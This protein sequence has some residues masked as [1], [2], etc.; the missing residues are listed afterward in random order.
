MEEYSSVS[1]PRAQAEKRPMLQTRKAHSDGSTDVEVPSGWRYKS[2][3][4][5]SKALPWYASPESQLTLVSFVCFLCPGKASTNGLCPPGTDQRTGMFNALNSLG[6]A[7]LG[8]TF[9]GNAS[10]SALYATFAAVG[11]F[12][13]TV[14]NALGIRTALSFGG[15]VSKQSVLYSRRATMASLLQRGGA[16]L[17]LARLPAIPCCSCVLYLA[18]LRRSLLTTDSLGLLHLYWLILVGSPIP[19]ASPTI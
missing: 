10:N 2:L 1:S 8:D 9:A 19:L 4:L 6:G 7:G 5:R 16:K 12:A 13:G 17:G 3:R 15:I 14:V 11:F 18:T